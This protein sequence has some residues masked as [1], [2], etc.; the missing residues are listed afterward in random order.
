MGACLNRFTR[1]FAAALLQGL[2]ATETIWSDEPLAEYRGRV[3]LREQYDQENEFFKTYERF[4]SFAN[5]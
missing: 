3:M 1:Y 2:E 4:G 5:K